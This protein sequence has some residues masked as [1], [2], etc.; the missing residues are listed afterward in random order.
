[1]RRIVL[2]LTAIAAVAGAPSAAAAQCRLC[3]SPTTAPA[4]AGQAGDDV[5]IEIDT[6]LNFDR[7]ILADASP[8]AAELRPDGSGSATGSVTAV[9][10][11]AMVATVIVRGQPNRAVRIDVPRRIDLFTLSGSRITFDQVVTDAAEAP[12]LDGAGNLKFHIGGRLRFMGDE[13]GDY[14]GDLPVT[15]EYQ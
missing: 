1:M 2:L 5:T 8:G 6:A 14:R 4:Q 15:V 13:D 7:L 11:R 10:P 12:R 9:G 3:S